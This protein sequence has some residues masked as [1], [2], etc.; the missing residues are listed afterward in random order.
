MLLV[1]LRKNE[2]KIIMESILALIASALS[3]LEKARGCLTNEGALLV[4]HTKTVITMSKS[5]SSINK[6][7][8]NLCNGK[9]QLLDNNGFVIAEFEGRIEEHLC[10]FFVIKDNKM[11]DIAKAENGKYDLQEHIGIIV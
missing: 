3:K 4:I 11:F 7:K 2:D 9:C 5:I 1:A 10:Q 6:E 8:N